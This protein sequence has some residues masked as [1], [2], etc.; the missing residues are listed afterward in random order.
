VQVNCEFEISLQ[1]RFNFRST[2]ERPNREGGKGRDFD[3]QI[4][5]N[6]N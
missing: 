1:E 3:M 6:Y 5:D 4:A 2:R